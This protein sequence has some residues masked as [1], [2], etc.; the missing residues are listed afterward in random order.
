LQAKR[1]T[2]L[3]TAIPTPITAVDHHTTLVLAVEISNKNWVV[4]AHVPGTGQVKAKQVIAPKADALEA[5]IAG[6]RRRAATSE[7]TVERVILVYGAGYSG[8][9]LARWLTARGIEVHVIQPSSVPV[10]R[11]RRRAKSD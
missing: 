7:R 10:E 5:A 9:W 8:F 3:M 1:E 11:K 6:Y 2:I 4:A